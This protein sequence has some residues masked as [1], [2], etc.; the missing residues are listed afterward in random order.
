MR[1]FILVYQIAAN[2]LSPVYSRTSEFTAPEVSQWL[3]DRGKP[4]TGVTLKNCGNLQQ[5][6]NRIF[7]QVHGFIQLLLSFTLE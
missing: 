3:I 7:I 1:T 2:R 4:L 6:T 5:P